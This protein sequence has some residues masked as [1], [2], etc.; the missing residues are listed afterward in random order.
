VQW[1]TIWI[2]GFFSFLSA[3]FAV[4]AIVLA[5]D[6]GIGIEGTY[7]PWLISSLTGGI[8]VYAYLLVSIIATLLFLGATSAKVID[9]LSNKEL[10]N[11]INAK[12]N[13][14]ESGQKLQQ[15]VLES[16]Q[17][18]VF[19]VDESIDR[20]RKELAKGFSKQGEE[21]QQVQANLADTFNSN[22]TI[23]QKLG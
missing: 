15:K 6:P 11:E 14:L 1:K 4:H 16:L 18:R 21:I 2:L 17:A 9:E 10:L 7:Q 19:L 20:V 12:V 23:Y 3:L 22:Q 8:P 13:N 5:A